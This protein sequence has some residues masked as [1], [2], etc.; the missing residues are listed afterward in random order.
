PQMVPDVRATP[1]AEAKATPAPSQ[2]PGARPSTHRSKVLVI[3]DSEETRKALDEILR[4]EGYDVI[5][6]VD[7]EA[8]IRKARQL[9]PSAI[10]LDILLPDI[11]GWDVLKRLRETAE[12]AETPV[13]I[14]SILDNASKGVAMGAVDFFVKPVD[15]DLL[16]KSLRKAAR[17]PVDEEGPMRIL[18]V[19]D[20]PQAVKLVSTVLESSGYEALKAYGGVQGLD[21]ARTERPSLIIL[22][23]IM[24]DMG[25]MEVL[26]EL[27]KDP[28][29]RDIPVMVLTAKHL[30]KK[31][32]D[33]MRESVLTVT[34]K[35]DFS[36]D[37]LLTL[38]RDLES[39]TRMS[40]GKEV[41]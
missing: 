27:K 15:R 9:N 34:R 26:A 11:N 28:G 23:L 13:I 37:R 41:A 14:V 32:M 8:G 18:V 3:D 6:A 25:G 19:D 20:Q 12:T 30:S 2:T 16:L 17:K 10:I 22:D 7:G 5:F 31:D 24:P 1:A 4:S 39:V 29:T 21:L 35:E 36:R 33:E 40:A 38:L